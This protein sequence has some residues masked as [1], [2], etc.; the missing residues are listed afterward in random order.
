MN[1]PANTVEA[2]NPI[3]EYGAAKRDVI[4]AESEYAAAEARLKREM[5]DALNGLLN[6]RAS[7]RRT[8]D[9][10]RREARTWLKQQ[11]ASVLAEA[12]RHYPRNPNAEAQ[13]CVFAG[14]EAPSPE[15]GMRTDLI[16]CP[17]HSDAKGERRGTGRLGANWTGD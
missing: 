5:A 14:L 13:C 15:N 17:L 16:T 3:V 12:R 10:R 8:A 4:R 9:K 2:T 1:A 7:A 11:P 6:A